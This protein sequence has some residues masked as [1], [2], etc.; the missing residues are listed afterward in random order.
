MNLFHAT[1]IMD[2]RVGSVSIYFFSIYV[3]I[4]YDCSSLLINHKKLPNGFKVFTS[5]HF[6]Q[7]GVLRTNRRARASTPRRKRLSTR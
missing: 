2:N 6:T 1:H 7:I 4:L 3:S 5:E